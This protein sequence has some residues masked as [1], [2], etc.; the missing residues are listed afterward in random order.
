VVATGLDGRVSGHG[1]D[2]A[3]RGLG[4]LA[5]HGSVRGV[6]GLL[7]ELGLHGGLARTKILAES[8]GSGGDL[9]CRE[10]IMLVHLG[11]ELKQ[12]VG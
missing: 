6:H 4:R 11:Y 7:R 9:A 1:V 5:I 2:D 10:Y 12:K 8:H 3:G